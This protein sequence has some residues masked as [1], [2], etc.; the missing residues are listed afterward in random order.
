MRRR[1]RLPDVG[2]VGVGLLAPCIEIINGGVGIA[3]KESI[4]FASK[5]AKD[6]E[7]LFLDK[8]VALVFVVQREVHQIGGSRFKGVLIALMTDDLGLRIVLTNKL[9]GIAFVIGNDAHTL[10]FAPLVRV[11]QDAQQSL[12][13]KRIGK[14]VVDKV[15]VL[16]PI[17][18][19][20]QTVWNSW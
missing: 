1:F 8:L 2:L 4:P 17:G 14:Q 20:I 6:R 12:L 7:R 9:G 3:A 15:R 18:P 13:P 11:V 10:H 19:I 5:A 16:K